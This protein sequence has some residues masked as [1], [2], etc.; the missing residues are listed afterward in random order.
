MNAMVQTLQFRPIAD[1]VFVGRF[2]ASRWGTNAL[3]M[4]GWVRPASEVEAIGAYEADALVGLA[5]WSVTKGI[6][7]IY[8]LDSLTEGRGVGGRLID[9]VA[10]AARLAGATRLR[11]STTNDNLHALGFLQRRGF[12]LTTLY[13]GAAVAYAMSHPELAAEGMGGIPRRDALELELDL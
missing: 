12:R 8:S 6:A 11:T 13:A 10:A 2:I 9:A 7:A 5:T 4:S 3:F 1:K